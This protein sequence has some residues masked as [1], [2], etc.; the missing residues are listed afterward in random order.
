MTAMP[1]TAD[2]TRTQRNMI[3]KLDWADRSV[4]RM[5][6]AIS[7]EDAVAVQDHFWSFLHASHLIWFYFNNFLKNRG[8][9]KKTG[10][11]IMKNWAASHLSAS[12]QKAWTAIADLR[13]GDVHVQPVETEEQETTG[14]AVR[15]GKLLARDGKLCTVTIVT[16]E[17]SFDGNEFEAIDLATEGVELLRRFVADFP[18]LV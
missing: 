1:S 16:Y 17:V 14:L 4:S 2:T 6:D 5:N 3:E 11:R 18:K 9:L 12:E 15:D 10:V 8:D 7:E 13:N